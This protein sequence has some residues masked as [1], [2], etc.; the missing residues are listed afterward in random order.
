MTLLFSTVFSKRDHDISLSNCSLFCFGPRIRCTVFF[1]K[2]KNLKKC[3]CFKKI[4]FHRFC[5]VP[6]DKCSNVSMEVFGVD[7]AKL[8]FRV[9]ILLHNQDIEILNF[10]KSAT[11]FYNQLFYWVKLWTWQSKK[12]WTF[13]NISSYKQNVFSSVY[14][15]FSRLFHT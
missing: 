10:K 14:T 6:V 11:L 7:R 13:S 4:V 8:K 12:R 2:P 15:L 1:A 5:C 3:R 9:N